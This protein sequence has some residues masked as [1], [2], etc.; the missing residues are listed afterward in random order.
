MREVLLKGWSGL[1][2][3]HWCCCRGLGVFNSHGHL[4]SF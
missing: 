3:Y 4:F 1:I 2:V